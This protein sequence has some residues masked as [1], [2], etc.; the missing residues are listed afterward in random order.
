VLE[1]IPTGAGELL[2]ARVDCVK[3]S[4]DAD[5]LLELELIEPNLFTE[6]ATGAADRF[7]DALV[8]WLRA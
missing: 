1:V 4:G 2:Y 8:S 3:G 6:T 7:A 5:L